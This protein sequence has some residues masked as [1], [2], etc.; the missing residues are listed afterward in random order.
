MPD[1]YLDS[2]SKVQ[3]AEEDV[4]KRQL[5]TPYYT[6]TGWGGGIVVDGETLPVL[7]EIGR[8][9]CRERV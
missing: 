6:S 5:E 3:I 9:S 8:A 1:V 4:Y 7:G 2:Y